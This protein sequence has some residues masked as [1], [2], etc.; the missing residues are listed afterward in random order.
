MSQVQY[1]VDY[2]IS[3]KIADSDGSIVWED[4]DIQLVSGAENV[5]QRLALALTV[6]YG[7]DM[8]NPTYGLDRF[9]IL[10]TDLEFDDQVEVLKM[11]IKKTI[12]E[13]DQVTDVPEIEKEDKDYVNRLYD[14]I[15]KV[16]I[17]GGESFITNVVGIPI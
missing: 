13:D 3:V 8:F 4:G 5:A 15:V 7:A 16:E 14:F 6:D 2:G 10:G 1:E 11:Q 17:M 9:L 12:L